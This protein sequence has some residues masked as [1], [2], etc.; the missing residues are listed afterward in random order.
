MADEEDLR[1]VVS[2]LPDVQEI[3]SEGFDFR[4]GGKG[5]VWSYPDR[6]AGRRI[7]RTDVAVVYVCDEAEKQAILKGEPHIFFT[8][9]GYDGFPLV[10]VR[11]DQVDVDRLRELIH[12]AWDMRRGPV[13]E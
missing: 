8:T 7:I 10:M 4:V 3:P 9:S 2:E 1:L 5:F 13:F 6:E 12:D 11:L